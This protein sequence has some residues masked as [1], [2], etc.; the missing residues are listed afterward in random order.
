MER[1][2]LRTNT[3][4]SKALKADKRAHQ[5]QASTFRHS[6][7]WQEKKYGFNL[8]REGRTPQHQYK[9]NEPLYVRCRRE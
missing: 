1:Q 9:K 5:D 6:I 4:Q 2:V 7:C 8:Q 3:Y